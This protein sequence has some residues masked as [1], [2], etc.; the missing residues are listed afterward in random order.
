VKEINGASGLSDGFTPPIEVFANERAN[1][2]IY[3]SF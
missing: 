2:D 1:A 3:Q